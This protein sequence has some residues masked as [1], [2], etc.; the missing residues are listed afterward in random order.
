MDK[1]HNNTN[2]NNTNEVTSKALPKKNTKKKKPSEKMS[3][4]EVSDDF[5]AATK[6]QKKAAEREA[7]VQAKRVALAK[8]VEETVKDDEAELTEKTEGTKDSANSA[9]SIAADAPDIITFKSKEPTLAVSSK[10]DVKSVTTAIKNKES[11]KIKEADISAANDTPAIET[12][13]VSD[14]KENGNTKKNCKGMLKVL[15]AVCLIVALSAAGWFAKDLFISKTINIVFETMEGVNMITEEVKAKTIGEAFEKLG[16]YVSDLD[17]VSPSLSDELTKDMTVNVTKRLETSANIGGKTKR[18]IL[19]P[20]TIE[21]N[22][23]FNNVTYDDNDI[24]KPKLS[25]KTKCNTSVIVKDVRKVVKKKEIKVPSS[26]SR[27]ILDPSLASGVM[28]ETAGVDGVAIYKYIYTYVNGKKT[29]AKKKFKK[30]IT[31]PQDHLIR[32]GTASTGQSGDVVIRRTFTS[33]TTAYYAGN[34]ARG[35]IGTGCHYG[36]CAVD[37]KVFPYGSRFWVQG[38]GYCVAN[39]CGGAIKGTKLDLYMTST[40]Q[41]YRWGRRYVTAYLL[42]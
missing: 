28:S 15:I 6:A 38:Y 14:V 34:N 32:L 5:K 26:G 36:T 8:L 42:G 17:T 23:E 40:K 16:I 18:F 31:E 12:Y 1:E 11:N 29:S 39:D 19:S 21:E 25:K 3:W 10:A 37:P 22:L 7:A 4:S 2:T 20:G 35:A 27:I 9:L 33:N 13:D 30:W 24:I 41:C